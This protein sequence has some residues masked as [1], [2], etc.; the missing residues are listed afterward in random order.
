MD[1]V[2]L[3]MSAYLCGYVCVRGFECVHVRAPG[4]MYLYTHW[5]I[6]VRI[7]FIIMYNN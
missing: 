3:W 7:L 5:C 1:Y 4:F 6:L 2:D